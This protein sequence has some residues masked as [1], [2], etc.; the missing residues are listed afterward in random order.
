MESQETWLNTAGNSPSSLTTTEALGSASSL[1]IRVSPSVLIGPLPL[2]GFWST[3]WQSTYRV[4]WSRSTP[5]ITLCH[6]VLKSTER[7]GNVTV[8]RLPSAPIRKY[9]RACWS[10]FSLSPACLLPSS[11]TICQTFHT[12]LTVF[13]IMR[14]VTMNEYSSGKPRGKFS[15][16]RILNTQYVITATQLPD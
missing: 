8:C 15:L 1:P 6:L 3:G 2:M 13:L 7:P 5:I 9:S 14:K 4:T 10:P 16:R 11:S 12:L